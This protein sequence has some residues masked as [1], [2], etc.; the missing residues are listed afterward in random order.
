MSNSPK[1]K[2]RLKALLEEIE[3]MPQEELTKLL[4]ETPDG[5]ISY[6]INPYVFSTGFEKPSIYKDV[7]FT[8]TNNATVSNE[9]KAMSHT[10]WT[11]EQAE[12]WAE[13]W[14]DKPR[15]A[16]MNRNDKEWHRH[17]STFLAGM[18]KAA[19]VIEASPTMYCDP[20]GWKHGDGDRQPSA[21]AIAKLVGVRPIERSEK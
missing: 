18:A 6:M 20:F 9:R 5:D 12:K 10:P 19:E 17:K 7:P 8:A 11:Q 3:S 2:A 4:E 1:T 15:C 21:H 13:E 14:C 16:Q